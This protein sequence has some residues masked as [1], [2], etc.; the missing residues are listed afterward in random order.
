MIRLAKP[1]D[2]PAIVSIYNEAVVAR[3]ATADLTA[4]SVD[5]RHAWFLEHEPT[6]H[7]IYIWEEAGE[8]K[9]W[10]SLSAYRRGRLALRFTAEIS[11]YVRGNSHRRGIATRLIEHSLEACASLRIKNV[12][13]IVLERNTR[14]CA[15]LEKL[16]FECWGLLPNVADFDGEECGHLY[17]G[18]RLAWA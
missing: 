5:S 3:F 7:P 11:Y 12:F 15:L 6:Q 18:R 8:V 14:S 16:G 4:V 9:G 2:L 17:Y 10:C 1:S 13:A